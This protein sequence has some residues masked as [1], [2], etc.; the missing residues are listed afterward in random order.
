MET[1]SLE[2]YMMNNTGYACME[3]D[4]FKEAVM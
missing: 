2:M 3:V 1:K 4:V